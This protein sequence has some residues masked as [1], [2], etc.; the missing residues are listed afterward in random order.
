MSSIRALHSSARLC[1]HVT[2]HYS[3][4]PRIHDPRWKDIN[5]ERVY[6][7][8]DVLI[9]GGGPAGLSAAIRL[10][11]LAN[12]AGKELKVTLVEKASEIGGHTLSGACI[13]TRALDE[14][15]PDWKEQGAPLNNPVT[16]DIFRILTEKRAFDIPVFKGNP[17]YN[18]GNHIVR[19]GH[20][21]KWLGMFMNIG[22]R[23]CKFN[24]S[25][26][27]RFCCRRAGSRNLFWYSSI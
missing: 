18:H 2:T 22:Y 12:D 10:K 15:L 19:L 8:S 27:L 9:V 5:M 20:F 6:D 3:V 25:F 1:K 4:V 21:V 23:W 14:L 24:I 7:E 17:V 11:K 26:C 16:K 13:E